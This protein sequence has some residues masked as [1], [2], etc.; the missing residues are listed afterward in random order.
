MPPAPKSSICAFCRHVSTAV[1]SFKTTT[2][3]SPFD[4]SF[5]S[6]NLS[7]ASTRSPASVSDG[8]VSTN[9]RFDHPSFIPPFRPF[10]L[11]RYPVVGAP[12]ASF[13]STPFTAS[14]N[15][16]RSSAV[17][18]ARIRSCAT[19]PSGHEMRNGDSLRSK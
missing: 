4:A 12:A 13:L 7:E 14:T 10:C 11:S 8:C 9:H 17:G 18:A 5:S 6:K 16:A 1:P 19:S 3:F 2:P 15:E